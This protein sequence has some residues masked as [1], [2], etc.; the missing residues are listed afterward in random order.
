MIKTAHYQI[1]QSKTPTQ[2]LAQHFPRIDLSND[3]AAVLPGQYWFSV[4]VNESDIDKFSKITVNL[5][6]KD[7]AATKVDVLKIMNIVKPA[8]LE[9]VE[10]FRKTAKSAKS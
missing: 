6:P 5:A 3:I 1:H 8:P 2:V 9:I 4:D 10:A 7:R